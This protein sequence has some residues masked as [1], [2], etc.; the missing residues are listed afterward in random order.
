MILVTGAAG[1]IGYH[2]ARRLAER[3]ESVVGIDNLNDY[4]DVALKEARV[5]QLQAFPNFTFQ[6]LDVADRA[7]IEALF[8][9]AKPS[10]VVHLAAQAGVRF[11]LTNPYAYT[12][13]NIDGFLNILEGCRHHAVEHLVF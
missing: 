6:A 2:V 7:G 4:Y 1:F 13:S 5:A 8:A 11:S 12:A 3:G 10:R 9:S